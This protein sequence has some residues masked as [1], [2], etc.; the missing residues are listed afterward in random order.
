MLIF[1]IADEFE[2]MV[3]S[4]CEYLYELLLLF[5]F[6]QNLMYEFDDIYVTV[7]EKFL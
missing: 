5:F 3:L 7:R 6:F 4:S 1:M 2:I